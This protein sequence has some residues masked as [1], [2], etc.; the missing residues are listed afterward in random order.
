MG[1][2]DDITGVTARG[3]KLPKTTIAVPVSADLQ[4][5]QGAGRVPSELSV[6]K[7]T[8]ETDSSH[9]QQVTARQRSEETPVAA[10]KKTKSYEEIFKEYFGGDMPETAEQKAQREKK[11]RRDTLISAIGDGISALSNLFFTTQYAPSSFDAS[12][13]MSA[14]TKARWERLR[15]EREANKRAYYE[16]YVRARAM[17]EAADREERTWQHGLER[18]KVADE[19]YAVKAAQDK[20]LADLNEKLRAHQVTAAEYKA[21]QERI[22]ALYAEGTEKLKQENLKAG[23]EQKRAAASAFYSRG[24]YYDNGGGNG[25]KLTLTIGGKTYTYGSKED[26]ERAVERYAKEYG[27]RPYN[28]YADGMDGRKKKYTTKRKSTAQLAAEVESKA[29]GEFSEYEIPESDEEEDDFSEF[30]M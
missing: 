30:E 22:A 11:E 4:G 3:P 28:T 25:K 7:Q 27:V 17:D 21:E 18:E 5:A 12:K 8:P 29:A 1:A 23:V 6:T 26:Y 14:A 19:R 20:A 24:R 16:G 10:P 13:G 9:E 15:Q 2:Y